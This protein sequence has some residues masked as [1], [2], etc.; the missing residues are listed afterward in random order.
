[1]FRRVA[2]SRV[3]CGCGSAALRPSCPSCAR[4]NLDFRFVRPAVLAREVSL[5]RI[6]PRSH[7]TTHI[8][9]WAKS[10]RLVAVGLVDLIRTGKSVL[11]ELRVDQL[12]MNI[13]Q[14]RSF[15]SISACRS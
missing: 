15:S 7:F 5:E 6:V 13:E 1:M 3:P 12:A 14:P 2:D 8:L 10:E 4:S 9:V 11:F